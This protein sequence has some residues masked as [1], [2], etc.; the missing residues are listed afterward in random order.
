MKTKDVSK[1]VRQARKSLGMNGGSQQD[2]LRRARKTLGVTNEQLAVALGVK[3]S[4]LLSYLAPKG[5]A[6]HR[7]MPADLRLVV[8]RITQE[9]KS[10][11]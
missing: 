1:L 2:L 11:G 6:K 5:A 8:E 9:A 4:T 3:I 7:A 10:K